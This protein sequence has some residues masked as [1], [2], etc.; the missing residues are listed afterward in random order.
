MRK[1]A[2]P[3]DLQ[4]ELH[5][6]LAYCRG[7]QPSREKIA[8]ELR[9]LAERVA[10]KTANDLP[11]RELEQALSRLSGVNKAEVVDSSSPSTGVFDVTVSMAMKVK[12]EQSVQ[13]RANGPYAKKVTAFEEDLK[14]V[15]KAVMDALKKLG[16]YSV[17]V[18][19][20]RRKRGP[21]DKHG[22]PPVHY[23]DD[24]DV[25]VEFFIRPS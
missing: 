25:L 15:R 19:L 2:S 17:K 21:K 11:E 1:I 3:Q 6:L 10:G 9:G 16:A 20:P 13:T 14:R 22:G 5:H 18:A 23:Y 12:K 7:H 8:S 24:A 4:V